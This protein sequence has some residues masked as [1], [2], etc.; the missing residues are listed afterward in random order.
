MSVLTSSTNRVLRTIKQLATNRSAR[1]G[2]GVLAA[3]ILLLL[4]M[5]GIANAGPAPQPISAV[6]SPIMPPVTVNLDCDETWNPSCR[7]AAA[8]TSGVR[9][10]SYFYIDGRFRGPA[11][12]MYTNVCLLFRLRDGSHSA[13]VFA[14]D[15]RGN[16]AGVGPYGVIKC[17]RSGPSVST[18]L[19][20]YRRVVSIAPKATDRYSGVATETL[21]IDQ[22]E[23]T[24]GVVSD[25]CAT[26][27]LGTGLHTVTV[28]ATDN[29]GNSSLTQRYFYCR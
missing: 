11:N 9:L 23:K 25:V 27:G 1:T 14:I 17:D 8:T 10:R 7:T 5:V 19:R 4:A 21:L 20:V 6:K 26:Y 24:W 18:G 29:V 15:A 28:Q 16:T 22:A 12:Q 3:S 13:R 2:A